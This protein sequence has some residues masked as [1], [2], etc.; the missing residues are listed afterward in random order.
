MST[1]KDAVLS[2]D[3]GAIKRAIA[4]GDNIND[5]SSGMTPLFYAVPR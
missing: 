1:L 5:M 2:S 3:Y 4:E